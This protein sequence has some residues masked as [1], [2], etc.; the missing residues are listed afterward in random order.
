MTGGSA[1]ITLADVK[2]MVL[3]F[4][5]GTALADQ[6]YTAGTAI[7]PVE[8][9]TAGGTGVITYAVADLPAG[10]SFDPATR[11]LAGT[12]E[13]PTD[14]AVNVTYTATDDVGTTASLPFAITVS[15]RPMLEVVRVGSTH[16]LVRENGGPTAIILTATVAAPSATDETLRF[17]LGEPTD[18]V[19][20]VRDLD[21][22]AQLG[23]V[24]TLTAGETQGTTTLLLTPIDNAVEDGDK[25]LSVQAS[26]SGGSAQTDIKIADDE[27]PSGA[28]ALSVAP[29]T[30]REDAGPTEL[31]VTA[32]LDGQMLDADATVTLSIDPASTATRDL[33]YSAQFNPLLVIPAGSASGVIILRIDPVADR[34]EEGDE[35][36]TINGMAANLTSGSV[37]ITLADVSTP[38]SEV[39]P[40]AFADGLS[41]ADQEYTAGT[42]MAAL[43]LPQ[44]MGG[45]GDVTYRVSALPAGLSFDPATRTLSGT[46]EAPTDSAVTVTYTAT[47][48]AGA[49]ASLTFAITINPALTFG[50]FSEPFNA[51]GKVL[52]TPSDD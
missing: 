34:E 38:P 17:T 5:D 31:T 25:Y 28:I 26:A 3:A 43:E 32:T 27:A 47:D 2:A 8:L 10:L 6:E 23:G 1:D 21:Y 35:T 24:I 50:G 46:P 40:L 41:V 44:A 30:V 20:A 49:T 9:P 19:L 7:A 45:A 22:T 14:G 51:A 42:T 39:P 11:T 18:G 16:S 33:D 29:P 52:P 12:P 48:A 37:D 4:A 13:A 15:P 36:I